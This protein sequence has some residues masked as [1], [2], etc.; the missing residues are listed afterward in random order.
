VGDQAFHSVTLF[1]ADIDAAARWYAELLD[2][3]VTVSKQF[4]E[5]KTTAGSIGFH[6]A[7][8][9]CPEGVVVAYHDTHDLKLSMKKAESNGFK[10]L[11][12]PLEIDDHVIA[13][14]IDK[15]GIRV[16]FIERKWITSKSVEQY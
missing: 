13:Q 8:E 15:H 14:A 2:A 7:D 6:T 4:S 11:R 1:V 16:G 9:K 3:E 10:L 12:G 5:I